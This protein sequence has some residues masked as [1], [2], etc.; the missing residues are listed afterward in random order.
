MIFS[1][2]ISFILMITVGN[3]N[4]MLK[5]IT[6]VIIEFMEAGRW[7]TGQEANIVILTEVV[8]IVSWKTNRELMLH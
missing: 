6:P 1:E 2:L 4:G 3:T 8:Y 5:T 7:V